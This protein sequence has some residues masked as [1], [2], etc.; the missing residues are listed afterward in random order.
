[1]PIANDH[2]LARAVAQASI[3]IQE[4]QDYCG[5]SLSDRSKVNFPRGLIGTADSYRAKCPRYL[6][7]D[8]ISSCAY[9]FM[10]L[11][12]LWWVLSR[13]DLASVGKQMCVKSAI[14]TLGML[15]EV[16]LWIPDLPRNEVLSKK[17][18]AGVIPRLKETVARGW[19]DDVQRACLEQLWNHRN[20]VHLKILGDSERN[21]YQ[22]EDINAPQ[23]ALLVLM[24]KL[25]AWHE[26]GMPPK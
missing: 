13:T 17:C 10:Y 24:A 25:R 12:V 1:M 9:G 21:L 19:I 22:V 14:I 16:I 6:S 3:H 20:N 8:Q 26:A 5:R 2:E 11:D 15:L 18:G 7:A 4:I 23:A